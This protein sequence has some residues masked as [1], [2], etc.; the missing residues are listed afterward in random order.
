MRL[1]VKHND[2]IIKELQFSK[3]PIYIGRH[4]HSQVSL[5]DTSVSRRHAVLTET[6]QGNW[7]IEDLDSANKT[8]LNA[9]QVQKA[10][11]QDGDIIRIVDFTIDV[12]LKD[13]N[14]QTPMNLADTLMPS[15]LPQSVIIRNTFSSDAPPIRIPV[16]R[17]NQFIEATELICET[18]LI[19]DVVKV[20][21][22]IILD[23][24]SGYNC[25]VG[26]RM[27]VEGPLESYSGKNRTG[28]TLDLNEIKL[29]P[30]INEALENS[31]YFLFPR[32]SLPRGERNKQSAMIVP[33]V[34]A[35][36]SYGVI[37][38]DNTLVHEHYS[39]ADLDYLMLIAIHTAA[40]IRNF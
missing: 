9:K 33:V 17:I 37:Y 27:Q 16:T 5:P 13:N 28:Q 22:K 1:V 2:I 38:V 15:S 34:G 26:L 20:L 23:Q 3:G 39:L 8:Y 31:Q 36:G 35:K 18:N 12:N 30:K 6:E 4:E 7:L 25:W 10:E 40:F 14:V 11:I 24:L 19:E 32:L 29:K 21:I